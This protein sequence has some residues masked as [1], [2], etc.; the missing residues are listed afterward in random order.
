MPQ[1]YY[2]INGN[3]D[4][5]DIHSIEKEYTIEEYEKNGLPLQFLAQDITEAEYEKQPRLSKD[6]EF[7]IAIWNSEQTEIVYKYL[8][9]V[10]LSPNFTV[11][12]LK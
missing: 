1:I 2:S 5:E 12:K 8:G 10:R 3:D 7:E 11:R 9:F 4:V 6:Y